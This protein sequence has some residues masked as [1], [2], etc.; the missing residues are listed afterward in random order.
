[1]LPDALIINEV[2]VNLENDNK[3]IQSSKSDIKE[4]QQKD[5]NDLKYQSVNQSFTHDVS[6]IKQ[7]NSNTQVEY[8]LLKRNLE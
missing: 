2:Q 7:I 8:P 5:L 1:M 3:L 6:S 4:S